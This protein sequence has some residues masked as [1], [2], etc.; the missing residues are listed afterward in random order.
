[1]DA[2]IGW[3]GFVG[4]NL[5][6]Q[7]EFGG[8]FN[9]RNIGDIA[10]K[11]FETVVCAAA[12]ATMW[13]A[14]KDPQGDL[15]NINA[16]VSQLE[17]IEANAFVLIST[18]AVL[19]DSSGC[20]E[21]SDRFEQDKSYGRNRRHLEER[22]AGL[23]D[24][25]HILRL[26]ALFGDG[27]KKNFVFDMLNPAPSFL[28]RD[29]HAALL[30]ELPEKAAAILKEVYV[31]SDEIG[32]YRCERGQLAG[33]AGQLLTQS[34]FDAGFTALNFT[35]ADSTFQ[36]YNLARLWSDIG[37]VM[38]N[39]L[40]VA[41]LAPAPLRAGDIHRELTGSS[42]ET[43]TATL[44][45]EDMRTRHARLWGQDGTYIQDGASVLDDLRSFYT[46]AR[47]S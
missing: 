35:N 4:G 22:I 9:S 45:H 14:N 34:L 46:T 13:A 32:M 44:Y 29:K 3:T 20:D 33:T 36:Y 2:L 47:A 18:I 40:S 12:P 7:H 17:R 27:L 6:A 39:A 41:H 10:G 43:R 16:L 42:L 1:M 8:Q 26:P 25:C 31:F 11:R 5:I 37:I 28:T 24:R 19:A 23:F 21:T 30:Q 15:D 38:D